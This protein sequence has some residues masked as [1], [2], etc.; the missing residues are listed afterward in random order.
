MAFII[1]IIVEC[2]SK[3]AS[4]ED[5]QSCDFSK[6]ASP[7]LH[8]SHQHFCMIERSDMRMEKH[9]SLRIHWCM[10]ILADLAASL[11]IAF[12]LL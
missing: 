1:S 2:V 5:E 12:L 4:H 9:E 8:N 6:H 3:L 11:I 10:M 7:L